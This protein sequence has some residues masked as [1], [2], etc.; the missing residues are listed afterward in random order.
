[1]KMIA[2]MVIMVGIALK[3]ISEQEGVMV[4]FAASA[5]LNAKIEFKLQTPK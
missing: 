4:D 1:M 5:D 2:R 3:M